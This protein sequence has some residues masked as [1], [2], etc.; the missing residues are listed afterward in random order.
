MREIG[1][2]RE[3]DL[4]KGNEFYS[5]TKNVARL[6]SGRAG[7]LYALR[8][9]GCKRILIPYYQCSTVEEILVH[10]GI[11]VTYYHID[12]KFRPILPDRIDNDEAILIVNYFGLLP[13]DNV[14]DII[15]RYEKVIIDNTQAF[16]CEPIQNAYSVYSPRKFFGVPDGAYVIGENAEHYVDHYEQDVSSDSCL[17]LLKRI[18]SGGNANY[19]LY[20]ENEARIS[21]SGIKK[22][23]ILTHA[24]LDNI[25]YEKCAEIRKRNYLFA[26]KLFEDIN[27]LPQEVFE[28]SDS[29]VLPMAYPLVVVNDE[30]RGYLKEMS[31]Y[32]GQLWKYVLNL[33]DANYTE[34]LYS[35]YLLPI[36]LDHRYGYKD[37]ELISS[38]IRKFCEKDRECI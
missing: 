4:V 21:Q 31:I 36:P 18:E 35:K 33:E 38:I 27:V 14:L 22:M 6:N 29:E 8:L 17:H 34:K 7:I 1:G 28:D 12:E 15:T 37:I 26:K 9:L 23:S 16:F 32:V 3:L 19:G 2:Y 13:K 5:N 11:N 10:N 25:D 24:L 20:L 30:L